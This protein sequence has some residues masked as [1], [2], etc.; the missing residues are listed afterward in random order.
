[1]NRNHELPCG[2][3]AGVQISVWVAQDMD[4]DV[5]E[6]R[7]SLLTIIGIPALLATMCCLPSVVLV[8]FGLASVS[9]AAS[10][11][12]TLYWGLDG[13]G[14]FRP[15]LLCISFLLLVGG[16]VIYFR[17]RGICTLDDAL[18]QRRKV[19]NTTLLILTTSITL[20]LFLNY[21]VLT[22][23]GILLGLPW[24]SSRVWVRG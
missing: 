6:G 20:Y 24:E 21:V 4:N 13:W 10:L 1:M 3:Q 17:N 11:S 14:W 8:L 22:E 7:G 5:E 12:D 19:V 23:I 15:A 2:I 9:A 18:R 16:I